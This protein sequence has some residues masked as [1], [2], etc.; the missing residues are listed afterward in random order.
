MR[1]EIVT[2]EE[3]M[4]DV[5]GS[6]NAR[7]GRVEEIREVSGKKVVKGKAPLQRMFGYSTELRSMSQGRA[8]YTMHY[9]GH[10]LV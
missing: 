9:A 5:I 6:L 1:V 7:R 2:P 4:G 3:F 8:T 10:D